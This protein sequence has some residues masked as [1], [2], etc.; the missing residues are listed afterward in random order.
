MSNEIGDRNGAAK[1]NNSSSSEPSTDRH[2]KDLAKITKGG[3]YTFIG[4]ALGRVILFLFTVYLARVFGAAD[5]GLYFLTTTIMT[6][7]ASLANFGLGIGVNRYIAIFSARGDRQRMK[8]V[9]LNSVAFSVAFSTMIV[10]LIFIF[11]DFV[12]GKIFHKP[13]VAYLLKLLAFTL[14]FESMMR[15][16][17]ASTNGLKLMQYTAITENITWVGLRFAFTGLFIMMFGATLKLA[18]IAYV[19]SSV[20]SAGVAFCS[21]K[22]YI[23]LLDSGIKS[24]CDRKE[25]FKFSV[26]M[27]F[28]IF[29]GN[30][31][32]Q[33]DV[34]MIGVYLSS[35]S[36][37]IYAMAMRI[38]IIAEFI[39]QIFNPIFY[40]FVS[41]LN[42]KKDFGRLSNLLKTVTRW[43]VNISFPIFMTLILFPKFF[44]S[45]FGQEFV[46]AYPCL[47]ILVVARILSSLS[48][49][50][51]TMIFM[52][53]R[54]DIT[55]RNNLFLLVL[56]IGLNYLL[57]PRFGVI[58]AALSASLCL[59]VISA[60]RIIEVYHLMRIHPFS[61]ALWKP[62]LAGLGSVTFILLLR[63]GLAIIRMDFIPAL[64][65]VF[66][67]LYA[68]GLYLFKLDK[69]D[70]YIKNL[71]LNKT[72]F[73][74]KRF[75]R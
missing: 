19:L 58:G 28:S 61:F 50:P 33:M 29:L 39:F 72:G 45:L 64:I 5:I 73:L 69:E 8:G 35:A 55:A 36:V 44:L 43:N 40:P 65:V 54:S 37:G 70:I 7:L 26:P 31:S 23:P 56:A 67:L 34:L 74:A 32:R 48:I 13:E 1:V 42:D 27:V 46:S 4:S 41:E 16:F 18:V 57:I 71:V 38:V 75:K 11:G 60:T 14:P 21:S 68:L 30:M 51:S 62:L 59:F 47:M 10:V 52:T 63:G 6:I 22:K 9:V 17:L 20:V 24:T 3:G 15:V 2:F 25:L 12:V 66:F 49:L 53:G